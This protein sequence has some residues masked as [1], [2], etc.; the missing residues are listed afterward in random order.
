MN[1]PSTFVFQQFSI[2]QDQCAMKVGID[3]VILGAKTPVHDYKS[4]LDIGTGTGVLSLMMAQRTNS[5]IDAIEI[6]E[7][8]FLQ[9]KENF[10]NS[11][12]SNRI[13]IT[14]TAIQ[15]YNPNKRYD[16][17]ICNP[18]YFETALKSQ[19]SNRNLAR[20]NDSLSL[21]E[22]FLN[23]KRL[24]TNEG[25]LS[26]ILPYSAKKNAI[27]I[28]EKNQLFCTKQTV[29][30]G[31]AHK[32]PNRILL[33]FHED[34]ATPTIDTLTIYDAYGKYTTQFKKLTKDFYLP[35]IFR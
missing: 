35:S 8:A 6:E 11:I 33:L 3:S 20:H 19:D 13:Q 5:E 2:N 18:P 26:I 34:Q 24:L 22:L 23:S 29:I 14:H 1:N 32:A 25:K 31:K 9:A 28:A 30:N 27:T 4:I 12:F 16:L 7:K 17:I 21:N 10:K 15:E